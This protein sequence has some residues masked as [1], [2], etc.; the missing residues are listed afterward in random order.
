MPDQTADDDEPRMSMESCLYAGLDYANFNFD[1]VSKND[2]KL[3]EAVGSLLVKQQA[4]LAVP[5]HLR[6]VAVHFQSTLKKPWFDFGIDYELGTAGTY[7]VMGS[8]SRFRSVI[9][10][11]VGRQLGAK[12]QAY[13]R[14]AIGCYLL[15]F[16]VASIVFC[17]AAVEAVLKE[18]LA[19]AGHPLYQD[20]AQLL[21]PAR[22]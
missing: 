3:I 19:S 7:R 16:D 8:F 10:V 17:R 15:M 5:E 20:A 14:E 13:L 6:S 22:C 1:D 9:P 21:L 18:A 12:A 11:Y 4:T 2:R